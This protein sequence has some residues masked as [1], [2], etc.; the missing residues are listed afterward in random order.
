MSIAIQFH[1]PRPA[2]VEHFPASDTSGEF[3]TLGII[4]RDGGTLKAF[5]ATPGDLACWLRGALAKTEQ[6]VANLTPATLP[7]E[8]VADVVA[9]GVFGKCHTEDPSGFICTLAV[10]H[11]GD[12]EAHGTTTDNAYATWSAR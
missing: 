11:D 4:E 9:R 7:D 3:A 5:F 1:R 6:L 10:N 2:T 8:G 12:H